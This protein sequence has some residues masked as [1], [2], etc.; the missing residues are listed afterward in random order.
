MSVYDPLQRYLTTQSGKTLALS[1]SQIEGILNRKLP[2][3]AHKHDEWWAN[4][5]A[6]TTRHYQCRAWRGAGWQVA[7]VDRA[8]RAV[9]FER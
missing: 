6:P 9:R 5:S 4:E 2:A 1:F 3:S 7:A 8:R